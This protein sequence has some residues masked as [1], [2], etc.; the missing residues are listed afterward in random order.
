MNRMRLLSLDNL[1]EY[2][3]QQGNSVHFSATDENKNIVVQV[4]GKL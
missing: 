3:E 4:P 2:Y 1:Y